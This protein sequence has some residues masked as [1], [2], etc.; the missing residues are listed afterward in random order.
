MNVKCWVGALVCM[1]AVAWGVT[2]SGHQGGDKLVWKAFDTVEKPFWQE[3][4]TK[5]DQT[6]KTQDME[7]V[8]NQTQTFVFK[9]TPKGK[10]QDGNWIVDQEIVA[11]KITIETSGKET[12]VDS[13]DQNA[14]NN[15]KTLL[16][17]STLT[18]GKDFKAVN[19]ADNQTVDSMFAAWPKDGVLDAKGWKYSS[20]LNMGPIGS[21]DT[22]YTYKP[23]KGNKDKILVK[24]TTTYKVPDGKANGGL[25]FIIKSGN[26]STE[27]FEGVV[28][29]DPAAGRIKSVEGRLELKGTLTI[30]IGG[31]V[32]TVDVIQ[33]QTSKMNITDDDPRTK[34]K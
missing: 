11:F 14:P 34:K 31:M 6:M 13:E 30:D 12:V 10:D 2:A 18:I 1:S 27:K 16:G 20:V 17:R 26:L 7:I 29:L 24:A 32:T 22:T 33:N 21:Y 3:L 8:Q 4:T 28:F 25:P 19:A 9:W 15:I 5:T 23:D